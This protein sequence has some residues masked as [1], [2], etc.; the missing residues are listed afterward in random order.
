[1]D[2]TGLIRTATITGFAAAL[3]LATVVP[4]GAAPL[5]DPVTTVA[6]LD[7]D[8]EIES[9]NAQ[10]TGDHE[11]VIWATVDGVRASIT[12]PADSTAPFEAPR[13]ADLNGDGRAELVVTR[14]VGA[15]T[16]HFTAVHFDGHA[17]SQVVGD[18]NQPFSFA[19][20]GGVATHLGYRCTADDEARTFDTVAAEADDLGAP[21]DQ[22]TYSGTRTAHTLRDG[23]LTTR[24]TVEFTG[25][26]RTDPVLAVDP[27]TC[28]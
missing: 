17:L 9:V 1:M 3:G 19:E 8:G 2:R 27:A 25:R 23:A 26:P 14:S 16:T 12:L 4:A 24:D 22:L 7:G 10:L 5:A 28:A 15:N 6:D 13:V 18:D 20:G 11:Q 21:A